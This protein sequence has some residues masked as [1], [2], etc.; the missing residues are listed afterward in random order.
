M[1]SR[2]D[3]RPDLPAWRER[4]TALRRLVLRRRRLLAMVLMAV[5]V[6][7]AV[8]TLAPPAP[9]TVEVL[10][11]DRDLPAGAVLTAADLTSVALPPEAAPRRLLPDPIGATLA[12][13][14]GRGEPI[15]PSRVVG[16]ALTEAAPGTVAVPVRFSDPAQVAL[17]RVGD[18]VDVMATD[19]ASGSTDAVVTGVVVL[20][21]PDPTAARTDGTL[22]G[23]LVVLGVP[24]HFTTAITSATVASFVTFAWSDG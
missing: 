21:L 7:S 6:A 20:G 23:R 3:L 14:V 4:L 13:P 19:P 16:A 22:T 10:V 18:R 12:G 5:S 8:H 15:T 24:E 2:T 17:L 9:A 1:P 11:A